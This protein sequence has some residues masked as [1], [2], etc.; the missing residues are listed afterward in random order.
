MFILNTNENRYCR[1]WIPAVEVQR[2]SRT[3]PN[4]Y[5]Q[6]TTDER[7]RNADCV[8][9]S[10]VFLTPRINYQPRLSLRLTSSSSSS[11]LLRLIIESTFQN[12]HL[13]FNTAT[14]LRTPS[15]FYFLQADCRFPYMHFSFSATRW[16]ANCNRFSLWVWV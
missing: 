4:C 11:L 1:T 8:T 15:K 12:A 5:R 3:L 6:P 14:V 16:S 2:S 7:L 13:I 10:C 9:G